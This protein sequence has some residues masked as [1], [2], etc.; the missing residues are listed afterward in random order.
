MRFLCLIPA[1][2]AGVIADEYQRKTLHYLLASRLSSA[3][4]VLGKLGARMVHVG[5]FVALGVPV[6]CL[7]AL[8]GGLNP[9]ESALRL[10]RHVNDGDFCLG[11][12]ALVSIV[13]RRP[14][15]AIVV[16]YSSRGPLGARSILARDIPRFPG[17]S[18]LVGR[19][20]QQVGFAGQPGVRVGLRDPGDLCF[21]RGRASAAVRFM[22]DFI[23][24]F[25]WM[26]GLQSV[27]GLLLMGSGGR[28]PAADAGQLVAWWSAPDGLVVA[29][30]SPHPG[31][32]TPSRQR[33]L[34]RENR[35]L[36]GPRDRAPCGDDPMLW[37][38][39]HTSHRR[40]PA[41]LGSR[42]MVLFFSVLLGCYLLDVAYP[43]FVGALSGS[44]RRESQQTHQCLPCA[45]RAWPWPLAGIL[46]VAAS[47]AVSLTGEREQDT[48]ISLATT[49]LTPAEVVRAKQLAPSGP[50]AASGSRSLVIW[51]VGLL[52]GAPAPLGVLASIVYVRVIAWLVATM[53]VFASSSGQDFDPCSGRDFRYRFLI[54]S[55]FTQWPMFFV[56]FAF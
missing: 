51:A 49:L 1:L 43:V 20:G 11:T 55:T 42:P 18:P 5:T 17:R 41:W 4:I 6:V 15:D 45:A 24:V 31:D 34:S 27:L 33:P 37:K 25:C 14:R 8:Y 19:A 48:W 40:R 30:G 47:A 13:A 10:P 7:V 3:E 53:G 52:L 29:A 9:G 32:L 36:I 54:L 56:G 21:C 12:V 23:W 38:E 2:V 26:V 22:G 50:L 16:A 46:G 35:L 39:R 28:G 44:G